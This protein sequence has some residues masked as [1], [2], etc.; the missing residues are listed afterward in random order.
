LFLDDKLFGEFLAAGDK[1]GVKK[2][3]AGLKTSEAALRIQLK[4]LLA[5]K[6]LG[7]QCIF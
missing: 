7:H 1:A 3:D 6:S 2:D 4:A 5:T